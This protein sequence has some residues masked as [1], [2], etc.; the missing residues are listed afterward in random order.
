MHAY[1]KNA[2]VITCI[3]VRVYKTRDRN[4]RKFL[5]LCVDVMLLE[6]CS[7]THECGN[8]AQKLEQVSCP[9]VTSLSHVRRS[10]LCTLLCCF[11]FLYLYNKITA[12]RIF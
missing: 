12:N 9:C 1:T 7:S 3:H 5:L 2:F 6:H 8:L 11:T 4:L 10:F